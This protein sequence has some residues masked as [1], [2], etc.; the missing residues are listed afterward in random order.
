MFESRSLLETENLV[1]Q[2]FEFAVGRKI[3]LV[4]CRRLGKFI[5]NQEKSRSLIVKLAS[6]WDRRLLLNTKYKLRHFKGAQLFVRE[7]RA[8]EDR[9]RNDAKSKISA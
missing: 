1:K 6:V 2:A 3:K 7:N 8:P 5:P 9:K 4:D